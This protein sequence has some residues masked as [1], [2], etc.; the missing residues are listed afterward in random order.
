M[1]NE[2]DLIRG[3]DRSH[4]SHRID[5]SNSLQDHGVFFIDDLHANG[6]SRWQQIIGFNFFIRL[7]TTQFQKRE[8]QPI[9]VDQRH[10]CFRDFSVLKMRAMQCDGGI[11]RAQ[12]L[13]AFNC[14]L[15]KSGSTFFKLND[16][17]IAAPMP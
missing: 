15:V 2:R 8:S 11:V 3:P 17:L 1:Q 10:G 13:A 16:K 4:C 5:G 6:F 9:F 12:H 14:N 7:G